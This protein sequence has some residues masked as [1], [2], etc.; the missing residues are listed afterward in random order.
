VPIFYHADISTDDR[1]QPHLCHKGKSSANTK[2]G[3]KKAEFICNKPH[4]ETS[5]EKG[6]T[7][8]HNVIWSVLTKITFVFQGFFHILLA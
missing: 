2:I 1:P 3:L 5:N 6:N 4:H 8:L 7:S